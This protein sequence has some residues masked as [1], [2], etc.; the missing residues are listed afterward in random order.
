[1]EVVAKFFANPDNLI[2]FIVPLVVLICLGVG[3]IVY[4]LLRFSSVDLPE[5]SIPSTATK[6][7]GYPS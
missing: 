1:M 2:L 3:V 6:R 4:N 7:P 5:P